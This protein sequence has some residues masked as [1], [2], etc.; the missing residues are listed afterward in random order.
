VGLHRFFL[1]VDRCRRASQGHYPAR[2]ALWRGEADGGQGPVP[3]RVVE[4][5]GTQWQCEVSRSEVMAG[6]TL[7]LRAIAGD[8]NPC[9]GIYDETLR[10]LALE[11][12]R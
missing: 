3:A 8:V 9:M 1:V 11:H 2:I 7:D 4:V 5:K 6:R 10:L 12:F